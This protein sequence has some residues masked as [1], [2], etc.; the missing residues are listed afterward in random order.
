MAFLRID[1]GSGDGDSSSNGSDVTASGY[2]YG[3]RNKLVF[4]KIVIG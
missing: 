2:F 3:S 1:H 4:F